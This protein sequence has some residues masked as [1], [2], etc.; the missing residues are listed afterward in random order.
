M[1]SDI[2]NSD[3]VVVS[4][5]A[6]GFAQE[7]S[8]RSHRLVADEPLSVGGTDTGP[9]PYELLLSALGACTSMTLS[10]YARHKRWPLESVTVRLKH[11]KIDAADCPECETEVGKVDQIERE[12][13]LRG[14]LSEE[15]RERLLEIANNCP[16]HRT[17]RSEIRVS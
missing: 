14:E 8:M 10:M 16:I 3:W 9:A 11:S 7:L 15:Q 2:E 4:G 6:A 13:E 17:L 5:S 12:I 1:K